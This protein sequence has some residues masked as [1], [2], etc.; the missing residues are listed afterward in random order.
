MLLKKSIR[1]LNILDSEIHERSFLQ[2]LKINGISLL[3]NLVEFLI[4]NPQASGG[5][6]LE[7][8]RG[9]KEFELVEKLLLWEHP[10]NEEGILLEFRDSLNKLETEFTDQH[11]QKLLQKNRHVGLDDDEKQLL[12]TLLDRLKN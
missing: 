6:I 1:I 3:N 12:K 10:L 8:W 9:K 4:T 5:M 7:Q 2:D 11:I